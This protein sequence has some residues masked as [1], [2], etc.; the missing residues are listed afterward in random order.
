[1][2]TRIVACVA[3][4]AVVLALPAVAG[5]A[6]KQEEE[7]KLIGVLQ[8]GEPAQKDQAC[9]RLAVVGSKEAVP[10]LAAMLADEKLCD[11]AR[12][13]LEAIPDPAVDEA[14]RAALSKLKGKQLQGVV[15]T[16]GNRRDQAAVSEI[17][18]LLGDADA[19]VAVIAARALGRIGGAA[20]GKALEQA[21]G[22]APAALKPVVGEACIAFADALLVQGKRD[23][24]LA[25]Y[26]RIRGTELPKRILAA[27]FRGT[28]LAKQAAGVPLLV[29][30][31]KST[32]KDMF[33]VAFRLARELPGAEVTKAL[34]AELGGL[35]PDRRV[36]LIV[37]L[38][39]RRDMAALPAIVEL[40]KAGETPVRV[41]AIRVLG[42]LADPSAVSP[43]FDA[44]LDPQSDVAKAAQACLGGLPD[45][46]EVNDAIMAVAE[47]EGAKARLIA[48]N[49]IAD[50]RIAAATPCLLKALDDADEQVRSAA[51]RALG[52][53]MNAADAD[54]L[55]ARL[56]KPKNPK[57]IQGAEAALKAVLQRTENKQPCAAKLLAA[58]PQAEVPAKCAVLGLLRVVGG[59]EA[60]A[61]VKAA[62]KDA[63][64]EVQDAAIRALLGWSSAEPAAEV[65]EIA[66]TSPNETYKILAL[67]GYVGMIA[68]KDLPADKKLAMCKEAMNLAKRP[69]EKKL[70]LGALGETPHADALKM[71]EAC[72]D[73]APVKNEAA[74]ALLK[75]CQSPA[76]LNADEAKAALNKLIGL[77]GNANLKKQAQAALKQFEK[78]R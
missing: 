51:L 37:A 16:L 58:L 47:K 28:V 22:T 65:L 4:W 76:A 77:T 23:D 9:R 30:Q 71:I 46:K 54:P 62:C 20:A 6:A 5:D 56:V 42:Q 49:T 14:L 18:K 61:A 44:S 26:D 74:N 55:V 50:R 48:I 43:L 59:A 31:L 40:A 73:D 10:A 32:D 27:A 35:A 25:M 36:M 17:A 11:V 15:F 68:L 29:E 64:A 78:K 33:R 60:L 39:D 12:F 2:R 57:D 19:D 21:L 7:R 66:K 63:N 69:D 34:A 41:A 45:S 53:T 13:G 38:G 24:A 70:V 3:V 67:R 75:I 1:M 8:T 72:L 52:E